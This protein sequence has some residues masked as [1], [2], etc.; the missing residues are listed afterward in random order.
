MRQR[1]EPSMK[2]LTAAVAIGAVLLFCG[3]A[4]AES[5]GG[6]PNLLGNIFSG[7]GAGAP[8]PCPEKML[9]SRLG[10]PPDDSA[11]AP[12]QNSRT[13]PIATAAVSAFIDGSTRCL[14]S[15]PSARH[16]RLS[17]GPVTVSNSL[18]KPKF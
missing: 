2:A 6:F 8:A 9:P 14:I 1:V 4:R 11:R 16:F 12:P 17:G 13:A 5:S 3:G 15:H 10:K 7:Q 18:T